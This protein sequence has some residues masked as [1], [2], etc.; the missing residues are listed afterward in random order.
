MQVL[1]QNEN[2]ILLVGSCYNNMP[3]RK[4]R[5]LDIEK[6]YLT[7]ELNLDS[8]LRQID[9]GV[10]YKSDKEIENIIRRCQDE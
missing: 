3:V 4:C 2:K 7:P 9:W 6:D 10:F 5:I 1:A 8:A